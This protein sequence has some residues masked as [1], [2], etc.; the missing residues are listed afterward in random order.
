M[1][2]EMK[3]CTVCDSRNLNEFTADGA[4]GHFQIWWCEDCGSLHKQYFGEELSTWQPEH[5]MLNRQVLAF[6]KRFGQSIG[7]KPHVLDEKM[8]RFRLSLIAEEFKELLDAA[9]GGEEDGYE[10][11]WPTL[12]ATL[13]LKV[14]LPAF[15]DAL[16][17]LA[18]V[19]EG[20]AISM[21]VNMAPIAEAVHV[22]NMK[23][24]PSYVAA[25]DATHRG[26]QIYE[27]TRQGVPADVVQAIN[28]AVPIKRPDGKVLKPEGW[29]PPDI[30][31]ELRAQ[32]W[33][34][35]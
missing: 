20:T 15:A 13:P 34:P 17:D 27:P 31:G 21:G 7:D 11:R 14:D 5:S 28:A 35:K 32:G 24:L 9:F 18:Y 33:E 19:M 10:P 23:K 3:A 30:A 4:M 22:A 29:T 2:S 8:M 16:A 25:K 26:E 12:L 1:K 6:H